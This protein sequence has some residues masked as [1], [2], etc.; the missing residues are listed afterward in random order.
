MVALIDCIV[1]QGFDYRRPLLSRWA[2]L[3]RNLGFF[4]PCLVPRP[5]ASLQG[6]PESTW[7]SCSHF[8][9]VQRGLLVDQMFEWFIQF[10][11][12]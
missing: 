12:G 10:F 11:R 7:E 8:H 5:S 3:H 6:L 1:K 4:S 2:L 9:L